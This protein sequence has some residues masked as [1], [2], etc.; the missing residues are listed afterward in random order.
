MNVLVNLLEISTFIFYFT[1]II[2][3]TLFSYKKQKSDT[4]F[5]LGNRSLNFWLTALSAHASDMSNWLFMGFPMIIFLGGLFNAWAAIGLIVCMYFNWQFVAPKIRTMTEKMGSLT[6]YAYFE[7]RFKDFSGIIRT[8]SATM[9]FIFYMFYISAGLIGL[10]FLVETLFGFSYTVGITFGLLIVLFYVFLGGY[11]TV[12]WIDLFQ[13]FFLL[14]VILFVPITLIYKFDGLSNIFSSLKTQN[15]STSL[16]PSFSIKTFIEIF[17]IS[18]GWGLGYFG[19]PHIITKFMGIKNVKDMPKAKYVGV[20]WQT[21]ALLGATLFG[22]IGVYAFPKG[23]D[24]PQL[25]VLEIVKNNLAPFFSA[26]ILCSILAATTNV[27]AAQ[28]LVVASSVAE[29]YYKAL[30]VKKA[31]HKEVLLAS[32]ISVIV[33]G[34]IAYIIAY[35]KI[36]T[37]NSL[38]LYSWSGLGASFGPLLL[39]SLYSKKITRMGAF[40]GILTGGLVSGLWP[41]INKFIAY[42][43]PSMIPGFILSLIAI[44]I[45]SLASEKKVRNYAK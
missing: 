44:Y 35:F 12:A 15:L 2:I 29:D 1:V 14:F 16:F 32:R 6:L 28:I 25:I 22:I 19:Q 36:S 4:S 34:I 20:S 11:T 8:L 30:F 43:I 40:F 27:M 39:V 42:K 45:F 5:V 41:F 24:N 26:L 9:S 10:G 38:V 3:I 33:I 17:L 18:F 31:S 7:T 23:L 21:L 37:I 13:G